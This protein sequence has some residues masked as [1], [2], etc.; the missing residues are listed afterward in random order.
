MTPTTLKQ[1][2][3]MKQALRC[4]EDIRQTEA[5]FK[6]IDDTYCQQQVAQMEAQYNAL[7]NQLKRVEDD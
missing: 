6:G 3:L 5:V 7:M 1:Q 2:H 4:L